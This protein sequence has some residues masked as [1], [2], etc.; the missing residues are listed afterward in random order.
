MT[1]KKL[2]S[3]A[4]IAALPLNAWATDRVG[5]IGGGIPV[6]DATDDNDKIYFADD[7]PYYE[8]VEINNDDSEHIATTA[9]VKGAYNDILAA[10]NTL[11][12]QAYIINNE[13]HEYML[14]AALGV[15]SMA[16]AVDSEDDPSGFVDTLLVSAGGVI[17]AIR[18]QHVTIYTTWDDDRSSATT[19][20]PLTTVVPED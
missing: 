15:G 9:Y 13:T 12:D 8:N 11:A 16:S 17:S 5:P 6:G 10:I 14:P 18:S 4:I 1:T 19:V 2:L 20:V 3:I 7:S